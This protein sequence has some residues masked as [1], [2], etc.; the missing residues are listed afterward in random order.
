MIFSSTFKLIIYRSTRIENLGSLERYSLE[1]YELIIQLK[2]PVEVK[3]NK[4]K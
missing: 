2:L 1:G 3:K 4:K